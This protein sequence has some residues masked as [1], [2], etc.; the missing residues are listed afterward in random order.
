MEY[1]PL[2]QALANRNYAVLQ[3]N[4]RGSLGYG[5]KYMQSGFLEIGR[6][7]IQDLIDGKNW[8]TQQELVN[9]ER[10]AIMG[11]SFGGYAVLAAL[12]FNPD[13]FCCGI[14]LAGI[15]DLVEIGTMSGSGSSW[16]HRYFGKEEEFLK[17]MSP[18]YHTNRITKPLLI[19]DGFNDIDECK[20]EKIVQSL[21]NSQKPVSHLVFPDEGHVIAKPKNKRKL[22][23]AIETFLSDHL[24]GSMEPTN[25]EENFSELEH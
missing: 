15:T 25:S 17:S 22:F 10:V 23:A 6:K 18:L 3:V 14:D 19:I 13:E 9:P 4:Y 7:V 16:W 21:R 2:V 11:H 5:K 20:G 24:K 8:L 12:T 1:N